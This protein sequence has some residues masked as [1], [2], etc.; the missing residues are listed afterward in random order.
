[1]GNRQPK[2]PTWSNPSRGIP[3]DIPDEPVDSFVPF[4]TSAEVL[5]DERHAVE[6]DV[7]RIICNVFNLDLRQVRQA[8]YHETGEYRLGIAGFQQVVNPAFPAK[9]TVAKPQRGKGVVFTLNRLL[10]NPV[11]FPL[12]TEFVKKRDLEP[13][14][15]PVMLIGLHPRV[16]QYVAVTDLML[17]P[18]LLCFSGLIEEPAEQRQYQLVFGEFYRILLAMRNQ[19][20]WLPQLD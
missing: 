19:N 7:L 14:S 10:T 17:E 6:A 2:E 5:Q 18:D 1:M 16:K 15:R 11:K 4:R 13:S 9:L 3:D 20:L 12:I 8:T